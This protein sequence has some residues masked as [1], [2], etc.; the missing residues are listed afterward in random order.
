MCTHTHGVA[1]VGCISAFKI[2]KLFPS[3]G[4]ERF[5][6]DMAFG[7]KGGGVRRFAFVI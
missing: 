7:E 4:R 1:S 6:R 5:L 3:E 2:M